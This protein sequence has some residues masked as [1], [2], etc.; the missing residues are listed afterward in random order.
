MQAVRF[1]GVGRSAQ[2]GTLTRG[3]GASF[4]FDCAG[5]QPTLD[6]GAKLL[7]RNSAWTIVG[8]GYEKLKAGQIVGRAVLIPEDAAAGK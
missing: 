4:A 1:A 2:I 7:R 3:E 5:V 6:L 8:L